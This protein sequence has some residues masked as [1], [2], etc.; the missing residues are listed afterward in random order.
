VL[1]GRIALWDDNFAKLAAR[2]RNNDYVS[3]LAARGGVRCR[4]VRQGATHADRL[5]IWVGVHRHQ[6]KSSFVVHARIVRGDS[7]RCAGRLP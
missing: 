7:V 2:A 4:V 5:V 6:E 1:L 3:R